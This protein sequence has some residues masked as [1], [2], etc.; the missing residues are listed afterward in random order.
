MKI[1][2]NCVNNV[3]GGPV[4][5]SASF[6]NRA[7]RDELNEYRFLVSKAVFNNIDETYA[8][9]GRIVV[10]DRI[11]DGFIRVRQGALAE[12]YNFSPDLIYSMAGPTYID[13]KSLHVVGVSDGY[14]SHPDVMSLLSNR[15]FFDI[16]KL[17]AKILLKAIVAR[18]QSDYLI[19]QT[20]YALEEYCRRYIF[21]RDRSF[22]V[23]NAVSEIFLKSFLSPITPPADNPV[24]V[25]CPAA[26]YPHKD[27]RIIFSIIDY[28]ENS[29]PDVPHVK[30]V[31]TVGRDSLLLQ[32]NSKYFDTN[33]RFHVENNG[34]YKHADAVRLYEESHIVFIPSYFETFSTAYLEA[35]ATRRPLLCAD[36]GFSRD[37]CGAAAI[38]FCPRSAEDAALNI[39]R[40]I[41]SGFSVDHDVGNDV[42]KKYGNQEQRFQ[43]I[44]SILTSIVKKE[45]H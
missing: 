45:T 18:W 23:S 21:P 36:R 35:I 33:R 40:I 28:L 9:D 39:V 17:I 12:E 4:Q 37:I 43:A 44:S 6:I 13:F 3:K 34:V 16:V 22:V 10:L 24:V 38:Y 27:L 25:F 42:I 1:L 8:N 20:Q 19:F 7:F 11:R 5:N 29:Q 31:I 30:F 2:F 32:C 15:N 14:I 41:E 26:D